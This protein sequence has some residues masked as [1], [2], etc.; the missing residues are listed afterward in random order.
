MVNC[1]IIV[2]I[3]TTK[4]TILIINAVF[5]IVFPLNSSLFF[6]RIIIARIKPIGGSIIDNINEIIDNREDFS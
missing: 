3:D 5:V 2:I 6:F 4:I 1:K